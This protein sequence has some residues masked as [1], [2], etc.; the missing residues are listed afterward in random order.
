MKLYLLTYQFNGIGNSNGMICTSI[1]ELVKDSLPFA[2]I[3]LD[4]L[5]DSGLNCE[6]TNLSGEDAK[7]SELLTTKNTNELLAQYSQ[8]DDNLKRSDCGYFQVFEYDTLLDLIQEQSVEEWCNTSLKLKIEQ[9]KKQYREVIFS[10]N[11]EWAE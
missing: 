4:L 6:W 10:L 8:L 5:G 3:A 2:E 1:D 11:E 7:F 9:L